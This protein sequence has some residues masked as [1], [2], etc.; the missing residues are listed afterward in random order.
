MTDNAMKT[1]IAPVAI[2]GSFPCSHRGIIPAPANVTISTS[3][4]HG[5][6][7][8]IA[9]FNFYFAQCNLIIVI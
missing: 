4:L 8:V 9:S 7:S 5:S 3:K 2:E 1:Y 6:R